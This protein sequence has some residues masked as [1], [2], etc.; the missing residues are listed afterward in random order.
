MKSIRSLIALSLLVIFGLAQIV[1]ALPWQQPGLAG[2]VPTEKKRAMNKFDP[3][4][5]FPEAKEHGRKERPKRDKNSA[6]PSLLASG[7]SSNNVE[8]VDTASASRKS[9]RRHRSQPSRPRNPEATLSANAAPAPT[10]AV[11]AALPV[12]LPSIAVVRKTEPAVLA[13]SPPSNVM[14]GA[15]ALTKPARTQ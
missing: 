13:S 2:S 3:M 7:K 6:S 11:R 12:P 9:S 10:P 8:V 4:D 14:G 1:A 5:I 15:A